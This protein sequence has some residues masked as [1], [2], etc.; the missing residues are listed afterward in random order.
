[1]NLKNTILE[2]IYILKVEA[3]VIFL[4]EEVEITIECHI[5]LVAVIAATTI[6]N[7]VIGDS[8]HIIV[9]P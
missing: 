9:I 7:I 8:V 4:E 5:P 6:E 3:L 1:M 2:K